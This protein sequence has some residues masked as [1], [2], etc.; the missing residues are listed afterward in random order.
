MFIDFNL[1]NILEDKY[2]K[3]IIITTGPFP[4]GLAGTNRIICYCRGFIHNGYIPEVICIR[5]TEP[6]KDI[7]NK[8]ISGIYKG[9]KY[10]YPGKKTVRVKSFLG[11][12]LNDF[13]AVINSVL[14][15]RHLLQKRKIFFSIFYGN[16]IIAEL[17]FIAS[18]RL[19][20]RK[21]FKEESENPNIYFGNS[22]S[23]FKRAIKW[24]VI[25]RLYR[26]Y[27]G[28]FVMT[29]ILRDFFLD[30]GVP[31]TKV[32]LVPQT[33]DLERFDMKGVGFNN[34]VE[35][36]YVAY[37]GSLNQDKDGILTLIWIF[38]IVSEKLPSLRLVI[39]GDGT[40][41]EKS[42]ILNLIDRLNLKEKVVLAGRISS[43]EIPSFLMR[44]KLLVSCRPSS[45]QS[46]YGFPTKIVEYLAS[47][48]PSITSVH[49][50][51]AFYL[52]DNINAFVADSVDPEVFGLKILEALQDYG[53][54]INVAQKGKELVREK[55]NP[56]IQTKSIL[57]F[58]E[59]L[60]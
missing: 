50:D 2:R 60:N 59:I 43:E 6:Y 17:L 12:R 32:L 45:L 3:I 36:E 10:S 55:F 14:L 46:D 30:K 21:I 11:R 18:S 57:N 9:I 24:V 47:G 7:F 48:T 53:F 31:N 54:A 39:A 4:V 27:N 25:N 44:A 29:S 1:R 41:E 28:V 38:K 8:Q 37:I 35:G 22:K 19:F 16:N 34:N 5:P 13:V 42:S 40:L 52:K 26:Y 58:N 56:I 23:I 33:V 20:G 15:F 51:L 49:G